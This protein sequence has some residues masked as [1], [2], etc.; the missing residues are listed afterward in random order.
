M[1][2][3]VVRGKEAPVDWRGVVPSR[4]HHPRRADRVAR[5]FVGALVVAALATGPSAAT[6]PSTEV[7]TLLQ[8]DHSWSATGA[9]T[10]G[11]TWQTYRRALGG[12]PSPV[13][14][15]GTFFVT[16]TGA[17]GTIDLQLFVEFN[18]V[19]ERDLCTITGGSGD[20]AQL[21]GQGTWTQ[22]GRGTE[23]VLT[24]TADVNAS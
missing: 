16:L 2:D 5:G 13:A 8:S 15:A 12:L 9:F 21:A 22:V 19:Q 23:A 4:Q 24:C 18:E 20:Y 7:F 11:G 3:L 10:E 6:T 14:F 1:S 17:R